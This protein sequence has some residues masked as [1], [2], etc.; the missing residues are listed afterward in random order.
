MNQHSQRYALLEFREIWNYISFYKLNHKKRLFCIICQQYTTIHLFYY[1]TIYLSIYPLKEEPDQLSFYLSIYLSI[2]ISVYLTILCI[3][4]VSEKE[5]LNNLET[6]YLTMDISTY[7]SIYLSIYLPLK[8][9][10]DPLYICLYIYLSIWCKIV[11]CTLT[12]VKLGLG[13]TAS[14]WILLTLL[15]F[16]NPSIFLPP[17]IF[18]C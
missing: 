10:S 6:S 15:L 18:D 5:W 7:L 4:I 8:E 17:K 14:T 2:Y 9:E 13:I 12:K 11:Q 3:C 1:L 16:I